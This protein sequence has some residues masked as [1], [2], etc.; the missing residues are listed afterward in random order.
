MLD[1]SNG[2]FAIR[3]RQQNAKAGGQIP[4]IEVAI[5]GPGLGRNWKYVPKDIRNNA[6][7]GGVQACNLYL[8][9][10][11]PSIPHEGMAVTRG[12]SSPEINVVSILRLLGSIG[13]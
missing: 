10:I 12:G 1:V 5:A 3:F 13:G 6:L 11:C 7:R 4:F 9:L 8:P 2:S